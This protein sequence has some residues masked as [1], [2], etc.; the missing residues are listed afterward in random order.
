[1]AVSLDPFPTGLSCHRLEMRRCKNFETFD[2]ALL[3]RSSSLLFL[4]D[5]QDQFEIWR[6]LTPKIAR[7]KLLGT[8]FYTYLV[9]LMSFLI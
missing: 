7:L 1:M 3:K 8:H 9:L 5:F 4:D 2:P 6:W